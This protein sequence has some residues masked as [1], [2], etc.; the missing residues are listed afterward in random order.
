M[1]VGRAAPAVVVNCGMAVVSVLPGGAPSAQWE[2]LGP[3]VATRSTSTAYSRTGTRIDDEVR[4]L[5][6]QLSRLPKGNRAGLGTQ[7]F[8][9]DSGDASY[10]IETGQPVEFTLVT[11]PDATAV[12]YD[13]TDFDVWA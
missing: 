10:S 6:I 2:T 11:D 13:G 7:R 3:V 1:N 4:G 5:L 9:F 12:G 8:W